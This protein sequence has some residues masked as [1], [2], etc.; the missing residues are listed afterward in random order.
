M[1]DPETLV[2]RPAIEGGGE[3]GG[4][5]LRRRV[6]PT[7]EGFERKDGLGFGWGRL[8]GTCRRPKSPKVDVE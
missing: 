8:F 6:G 4:R 7:N 5:W 2:L 3:V 1:E